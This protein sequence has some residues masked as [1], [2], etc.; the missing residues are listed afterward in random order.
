MPLLADE[1]LIALRDELLATFDQMIRAAPRLPA[2]AC[3]GCI[4]H[5]DVYANS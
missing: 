5:R 1:K 2:G 4:A 3:Q